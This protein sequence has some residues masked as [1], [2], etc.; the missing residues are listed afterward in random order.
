MAVEAPSIESTEPEIGEFVGSARRRL[1][2]LGGR[3]TISYSGASLTVAR[4]VVDVAAI[5]GAVGVSF[6]LRFQLG[7]LSISG[8]PAAPEPYIV[9]SAIWVGGVLAAMATNR[10]FDEDTLL[11]G[12][13]E[14]ARLWRSLLQGL[15]L[16]S[17]V[18]F[19]THTVYVSRGWV[20]LAV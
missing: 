2:R 3:R 1:S 5:T 8:E 7:W 17:V 16:T 9:V 13:R 10:L 14:F 4:V 19:L 12:G 11:A 6:L 20:G 15:A 18:A